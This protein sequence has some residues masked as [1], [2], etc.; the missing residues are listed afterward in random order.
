MSAAI[1]VGELAARG[2]RLSVNG[3]AVR[4]EPASALT[5]EDRQAIRDHKPEI[6]L[7]LRSGPADRP[8]IGTAARP[9]PVRGRGLP[10]LDCLW[11]K[12][13]GSMA[14][15]GRDRFL[16]ADCGTWFQLLPPEELV[17]VGDLADEP[18]AETEWVN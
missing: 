5:D 15:H 8:R 14:L 11:A 18:A 7:I 1:L 4:V 9:M 2:I 13:G 12:C 16:C 6:L 17:Y 10:T 3:E